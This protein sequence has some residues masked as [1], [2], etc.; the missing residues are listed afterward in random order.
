MTIYQDPELLFAGLVGHLVPRM[1]HISY[2]IMVVLYVL[3]DADVIK[4]F[5]ETT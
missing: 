2:N 5:A 4:Y 1:E 3:A